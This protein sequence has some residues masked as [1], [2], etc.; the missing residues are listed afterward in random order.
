MQGFKSQGAQK[1]TAM[2]TLLQ[3][4]AYGATIPTGYGMTQSNLLAIWAAN[5]R[6]GGG[7]KKFKQM[8]KGI[9]NYVEN[10]DFLIGHSPIR[11]V[12][13]MMVNG[14]NFPLTFTSQSFSAAAG[15]QSFE[16][17]DPNFYF[18]VAVTLTAEYSFETDDYGSHGAQTL[19]GSYEIPLWNEL[20]TGPDPTHPMSYRCWPFCYRWQQGMGATVQVDAESFP[21]GTLKV[22]YAQLMD[23]TS[24][25]PPITKLYLAFEPQLGSGS[26]YAEAPAPF[27]AQQI[28]YPHFA[29]LGSSEVDL[30]ASGALPQMSPEVAFKWGVYSAGDAD[31]VD[32]IEDVFKSGLAQAAIAAE[33]AEPPTPPVTQMERGLSSYDLPGCS[34]K[35]IDAGAAI[36]LPPM[37]YDMANVEGDFL[38]CVVVGA[39]TLGIGSSAGD[40]WQPLFAPNSGYQV[41][42]AVAAGGP[43]TVTVTGASAPWQMALMEVN[44]VGQVSPV[45]DAPPLPGDT[46]LSIAT[47][48]TPIS[49]SGG[50]AIGTAS[51]T[52]TAASLGLQVFDGL[53]QEASATV[54][55]SGFSVPTLPSDA[56]VTGVFAALTAAFATTEGVWEGGHVLS[57]P[58]VVFPSGV[59]SG[60]F[61]GANILMG[62]LDDT[63]S[64][65]LAFVS[66]DVSGGLDPAFVASI[67]VSDLRLIVAY[68]SASSPGSGILDS[69]GIAAAS[70]TA[71]ILST[72]QQGMPAYMLAIPIYTAGDAPA[73]AEIEKWNLASPVNFYGKT[74]TAYQLQERIVYSSGE[75]SIAFPGPTPSAIALLSFKAVQPVSYP[76]PL[77]DFIDLASVDLVRAQCRANGLYGSLTMN[78]QSSGS[79]WINSLCQAADCAPVFMGFRLSLFPYSEVSTVGNGAKYTAPTAAGPV[80]SLDAANGDFIIPPKLNPASR[81]GVPNVLQMQCIDRNSQYN[82]VVVQVPDAASIALYG[83][84]KADAVVNNAIQDPAIARAILGIQVRRNQYGGDTWSFTV[85]PR[86]TLL[87][88]MDLI[89][90]ADA[91]QGL[92]PTPVRIT[93]YNEQDDGS[94]EAVAEPFVYGMCA[95]TALAATSATANPT[96]VAAGAGDVNPPAIFEPVPRLCNR[97]TQA[98]IWLVVSSGA[99]NYGGCQVYVSTDG[100]SSYNPAGDPLIGS[101][102]TGETTAVWPAASDPDT[103]DDLPVDLTECNGVLQNYAVA[104]EDNFVFPCYVEALDVAVLNNGVQ[105]ATVQD[106]SFESNGVTEAAPGAA[107]FNYELMTYATAVLTAPGKYTLKATGAGN[108]LRRAV[109]NAP[110]SGEGVLHCVGSRFAVLNPSSQGILKL[111]MD[112]V[113]VGVELFFK[114]VS[115]NQFGT[116]VQSLGD[117]P[118][119]SYTP[120]GVPYGL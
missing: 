120:T 9:V 20:E 96:G 43:N 81:I 93:S 78:S 74:P 95:P 70:T 76:R 21:A 50:S 103:T 82:Q 88:P 111:N 8:K 61:V 13:Q 38:V 64:T 45:P 44:G 97:Q 12:L 114:I 116:A 106:L 15:R 32:M 48:A 65:F 18:V 94:F 10:I 3:S 16:L 30:G 41:W 101:A 71:S 53:F 83:V 77:G 119:Y 37:T 72:V 112:P 105:V 4:S 67:V 14:S 42:Y 17:A 11:G 92:P 66:M 56:V 29:G 57:V 99:D 6:Q 91:L 115:F 89:T 79:D 23:A 25:Q 110:D 27:N 100:G 60:S 107:G 40:L 33:T 108:H 75:Y 47:V 1:P 46:A 31:F 63:I 85:S 49:T 54:N 80:A 55:W 5:L 98:Q 117:V 84:R 104:D 19:T 52:D 36:A 2:G 39:G 59:F 113:W 26:E 28:V 86:W 35:K 102:V 90:I 118:A 87:A 62:T 58:G 68:T 69:T 7:T 109:F 51:C 24:F 34:Q 22:Y 73:G